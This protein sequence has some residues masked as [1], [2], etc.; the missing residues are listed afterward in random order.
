MKLDPP[1]TQPSCVDTVLYKLNDDVD[2]EHEWGWQICYID[3]PRG[4]HACT[5]HHGRL[6]IIRQNLDARSQWWPPFLGQ[7]GG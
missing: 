4:S 7:H 5:D 2:N 3:C 6:F 1:P